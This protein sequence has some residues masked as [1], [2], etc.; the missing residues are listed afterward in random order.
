MDWGFL[1]P[2]ISPTMCW[3][4]A[5]RVW[6]SSVPSALLL[7][8]TYKQPNICFLPGPWKGNSPTLSSI[9]HPF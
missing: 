9:P 7:R 3:W 1:C 6:A 8:G 5:G 2:H 4:G